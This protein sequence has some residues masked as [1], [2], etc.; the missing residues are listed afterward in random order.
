MPVRRKVL[1]KRCLS[2]N[3]ICLRVF[4]VWYMR[5][6]EFL[7]LSP[8]SKVSSICKRSWRYFVKCN[9]T[10]YFSK[11]FSCFF[12]SVPKKKQNIK[13]FPKI[14]FFGRPHLF[15]GNIKNSRP[16]PPS[17]K[18]TPNFLLWKE[19]LTINEVNSGYVIQH[20][21]V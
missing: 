20:G 8:I 2:T 5:D 16:L 19:L 4:S 9:T 11:I 21:D 12:C 3:Y 1:P 15:P 6:W 10:K 13:I 14:A 17:P 18:I 7:R